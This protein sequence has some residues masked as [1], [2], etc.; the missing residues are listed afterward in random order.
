MPD[1]QLTDTAI[2]IRL[3]DG[4]NIP[5]DP[6]NADRQRYTQWLADGGVPL[7]YEPPAIDPSQ[8]QAAIV[9][10]T[11]QRLDD[12]ACTR[13]YDGILSACTYATST[14]PK[15]AAEGQYAV[16]ARDATWAALYALLEEVQAGTRQVPGSFDDVAPLLPALEWPQ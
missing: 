10:A 8:L 13:N 6:A 4:A 1:Y 2:V 11:Q 15:F 16:Q 3:A 14:V 5:S 12:F 9:Q 7:P